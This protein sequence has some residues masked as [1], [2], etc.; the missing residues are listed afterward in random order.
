V[1]E[2][3]KF[4]NHCK[5][6]SYPIF[7]DICGIEGEKTGVLNSGYGLDW[8]GD[9]EKRHKIHECWSALQRK[10]K[11]EYISTVK[12][13]KKFYQKAS[14]NQKRADG[15]FSDAFS[16]GKM[17]HPESFCRCTHNWEAH[18]INKNNGCAYCGCIK[19]VEKKKDSEESHSSR[20]F[21]QKH[22]LELKK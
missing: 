22:K 2:G 9:C 7:C 19:Y 15:S 3:K 16:S 13:I 21:V 5:K 18:S 14:R 11:E 10:T 17:A 6:Y 12:A 20:P 4:C 1:S 8:C